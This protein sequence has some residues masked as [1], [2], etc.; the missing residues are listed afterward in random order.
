MPVRRILKWPS[1]KLRMK[2]SE[3]LNFEEAKNLAADLRDTMLANLGVGLAAPQVGINKRILVIDAKHLPSIKESSHA[4]GVCVVVNPEISHID[5]EKFSWNEACLSVDDYQASVVR[6]SNISL[7]Y[8]DLEGQS[9][10]IQLHDTEAGIMQHEADH[11]DGKL[12]IDYVSHFERRRVMKKLK[13]KMAEKTREKKQSAKKHLAETKRAIARKNRKKKPKTFGK[14]K[15]K[16][17]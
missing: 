15:R 13:R 3:I 6:N 9:R 12:F 10:T 1:S 4:P 14:N 2:S 11:L 8:F 5:E 7:K 17:S 16:K